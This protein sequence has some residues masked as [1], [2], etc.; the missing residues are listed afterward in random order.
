M[1]VS[2]VFLRSGPTELDELSTTRTTIAKT[3]AALM[4]FWLIWIKQPGNGC[5]TN[6]YES[7]IL[8]E[9]LFFRCQSHHHNLI[10]ICRGP[11]I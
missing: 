2:A 7:N 10:L 11:I 5:V 6:R 4:S 9:S 3:Y 8:C 1:P